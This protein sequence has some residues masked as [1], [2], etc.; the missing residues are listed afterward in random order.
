MATL[1]ASMSWMAFM[2]QGLAAFAKPS[3]LQVDG[4]PQGGVVSA[5]LTMRRRDTFSGPGCTQ[6][7]GKVVN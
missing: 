2:V 5:K 4:D 3:D 6:G 7:H 1:S